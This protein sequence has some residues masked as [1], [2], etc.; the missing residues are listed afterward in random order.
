MSAQAPVHPADHS[1]AA[2][3]DQALAGA[4]V[5]IFRSRLTDVRPLKTWLSRHP[6][7]RVREVL[8]EMGSGEQRERF[9]GLKARTDWETLPQVFINGQFVGGQVEFFGHPLVTGRDVTPATPGASLP[10]V[11]LVKALGYAGLV[12]FG[13]GLL[14]LLA[15]MPLPR[16]AAAG[17][18]V[19][20]G[21]V[22]AT[23]LGAVHWGQA[24]AGRFPAG[25]AGRA[26][27]WAVVPSILAWLTLL[28][29]VTWALPLQAALFA[30]IL[31]VDARFGAQLGWPGY[32]RRLRL[33]L[34]AAVMFTLAT[35]WL[36]LLANP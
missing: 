19:A 27:V 2:W 12:P 29:P 4:E 21:A 20:Y 17:W 24:L 36:I 28:L 26:M 9:Q 10:P 14:M 6:E 32:Y 7:V 16:P 31:A 3:V 15:G 8:M 23:F 13:V 11:A 35:A 25:Q 5:V 1:P 34:S 33:I 30:L 18:L 22:I